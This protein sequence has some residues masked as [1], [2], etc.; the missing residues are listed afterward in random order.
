[1]NFKKLGLKFTI[2]PCHVRGNLH[3]AL[4]RFES[5]SEA[6]HGKSTEGARQNQ[7]QILAVALTSWVN[8]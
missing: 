7:V 6:I 1:M 8:W 5:D 3:V 2:S 4:F